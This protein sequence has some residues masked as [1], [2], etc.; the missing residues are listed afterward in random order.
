[1]DFII[2]ICTTFVETIVLLLGPVLICFASTIIIGLSWVFFSIYLPMM[3][4]ALDHQEASSLRR[5]VEIG[6]NV[7]FV[8][9]ILIEIIFNYFM[10][11]TTRNAGH[12]SSY[13]KV[14]REL[15]ESTGFEYPSTPQEVAQFRRRFSAKM[16]LRI[17]RR[18]AR[19]MKKKERK[20]VHS[21]CCDA[22]GKCSSNINS[23]ATAADTTPI[24][25][26]LATSTPTGHDVDLELDQVTSNN[27]SDVT[28]RKNV[29]QHQSKNNH[30]QLGVGNNNGNGVASNPKIRGWMLMAPDEWGYCSKTNQPKPPRSHYDHVSKSL[31]ICLD[32]YCPWMFNAVGYFNYRYFVNFLIYVCTAM[33]YGAFISYRPFANSTGPQYREQLL[34]Y[35]E[36]GVWKHMYPYTPTGSERMPLSLAFMMC[37]AVGI[38]VALLGGFHIYLLLSAQTTIEFH[39]NISSK[40]RAKKSGKKY[41]NP[42]DLG[43][44]R[45]WQQ[46]YGDCGDTVSVLMA[47]L[48]PSSREPDFLPLPIGGESGKRKHLRQRNR[49]EEEDETTTPLLE[50]MSALSVPADIV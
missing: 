35:R 3:Q 45:N 11:V 29:R 42:Y 10:C 49:E 31:V 25:V 38:A 13:D 21:R 43:W 15:A 2:S 5:F 18:Q 47:I 9:A 17:R 44:K 19:E 4:F 16:M 27:N 26:G 12:S 33:M 28:L 37:L 46:V 22:D 24:G 30:N 14:V 39:G 34:H 40:R 50:S 23:S 36:T 6:G 8:V 7:F 20:K 48:I 41:R 32:H 1:M